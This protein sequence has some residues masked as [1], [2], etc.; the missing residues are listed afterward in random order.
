[1]TF[2]LGVGSNPA[3]PATWKG[4]HPVAEAAPLLQAL[5]RH[6]E[7]RTLA[8]EAAFAALTAAAPVALCGEIRLA[9]EVRIDVGAETARL[10]REMTRLAGEMAKAEAKLGDARFVERAPAEV[11]GQERARLAEFRQALDR[12]RDQRARLE[13]SA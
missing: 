11:V 4:G 12:L 13:K 8:D 10:T 7:V 6:S 1:M 3:G 9:L 2:R 5:A